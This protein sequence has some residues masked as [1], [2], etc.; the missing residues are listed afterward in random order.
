[1]RL[2]SSAIGGQRRVGSAIVYGLIAAIAL[3]ACGPAEPQVR[4][5]VPKMRRL[6]EQQYRNV[7]AD[8]FGDSIVVASDFDPITRTNGLLAV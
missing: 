2:V 7:I 4:G 6:T 8:V 5:A 3:S 1:M